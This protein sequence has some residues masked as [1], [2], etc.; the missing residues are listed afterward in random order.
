[1]R[2]A[3]RESPRGTRTGMRPVNPMQRP[4]VGLAGS[5]RGSCQAEQ[6]WLAEKIVRSAERFGQ[7][8]VQPTLQ[9]LT[10]YHYCPNVVCTTGLTT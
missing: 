3:R 4:A 9:R 2:Y 8:P 5:R 10:L 6:L 7:A 1:M